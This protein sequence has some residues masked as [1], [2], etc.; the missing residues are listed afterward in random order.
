MNIKIKIGAYNTSINAS[1]FAKSISECNAMSKESDNLIKQIEAYSLL[2]DIKTVE[3]FGY[4]STEGIGQNIK[5][6]A[7]SLKESIS[8]F[9]KRIKM[10]F[11]NF[12]VKIITNV[13]ENII[14]DNVQMKEILSNVSNISKAGSVLSTKVIENLNKAPTDGDSEILNKSKMDQIIATYINKVVT[15]STAAVYQA[16]SALKAVSASLEGQSTGN[17][18]LDAIK[19][20]IQSKINMLAE[21]VKTFSIDKLEVLKQK[22]DN[23]E[24]IANNV[25]SEANKAKE[26]VSNATQT[27]QQ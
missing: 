15:K 1:T 3:S 6:G 12:T 24:H 26:T 2:S 8:N 9:F 17:Q 16:N 10:R 18:D 19:N 25:I 21:N 4:K 11:D 14:N 27:Q 5:N 23:I 20:L 7:I 22:A 13:A